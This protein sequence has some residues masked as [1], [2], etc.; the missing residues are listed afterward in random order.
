MLDDEY[1]DNNLTIC[2][3]LQLENEINKLHKTLQTAALSAMGP[4]KKRAKNI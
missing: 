4:K 1:R 2:N 3:R